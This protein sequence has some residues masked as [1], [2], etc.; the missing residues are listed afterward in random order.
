MLTNAH[1]S[2]IHYPPGQFT[3]IS[4]ISVSEVDCMGIGR[5][6]VSQHLDRCIIMFIFVLN[7]IRGNYTITDP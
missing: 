4:P 2:Y 1:I 6:I 5:L 7:I 3:H